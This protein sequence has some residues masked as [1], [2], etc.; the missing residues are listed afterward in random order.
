MKKLLSL[1]ALGALL[2]GCSGEKI[3][4]DQLKKKPE[5]MNSSLKPVRAAST[6][7][8]SEPRHDHSHDGPLW[9]FEASVLHLDDIS[10]KLPDGLQMAE[11]SSSMRLFELK[12]EGGLVLAA[13]YFGED[14]GSEAANISRWKGQFSSTESTSEEELAQGRAYLL[15]ATGK[16][17]ASMPMMGNQAEPQAGMGM[18]AAIVRTHRGPFFFKTTGKQAEV[19]AF[20]PRL[21]AFL[22]SAQ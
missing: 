17:G 14:A 1:C 22:E 20:L 11:S 13:F 10:L 2:A 19:A 5:T 9:D 3:N 12:D 7:P 6:Q 16:L 4:P 21:K 18:L 8:A 15:H